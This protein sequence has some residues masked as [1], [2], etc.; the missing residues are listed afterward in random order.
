MNGKTLTDF[1]KFV[2]PIRTIDIHGKPYVTVPERIRVFHNIYPNG[3]ISN[4]YSNY[5][6]SF[7][8]N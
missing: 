2:G 1:A 6:R 7:S 8:R 5:G 3:S 4:Q